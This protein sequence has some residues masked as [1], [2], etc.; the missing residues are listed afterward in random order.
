MTIEAFQTLNNGTLVD[1]S[2]D[3]VTGRMTIRAGKAH[4]P[5]SRPVVLELLPFEV[6]QMLSDVSALFARF[7]AEA[8]LSEARKA[9]A[10][11]AT[12]DCGEWVMDGM[13]QICKREVT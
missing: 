6:L 13:C 12:H 9:H 4:R 3:V 7:Q 1:Y 11:G 8:V 5:T 2:I 10:E